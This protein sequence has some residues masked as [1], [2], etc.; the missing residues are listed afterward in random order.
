MLIDKFEEEMLAE[1]LGGTMG[2]V[3]Y[4]HLGMGRS[5]YTGFWGNLSKEDKKTV[6]DAIALVRIE[7]LKYPSNEPVAT[8]K[9]CSPN[10]K[11]S[12]NRKIPA[13]NKVQRCI[14]QNGRYW[15]KPTSAFSLLAARPVSYTHLDVYKRQGVY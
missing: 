8:S 4:T 13:T 5:P 6:N 9:L 11:D 2:T 7:D 10:K 3:S 1:S 14:P 12:N 15:S